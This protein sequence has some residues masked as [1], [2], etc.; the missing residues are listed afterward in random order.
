MGMALPALMSIQFA[1][2]SELFHAAK[3][4]SW[5]QALITADGLRHAP[6]FSAPVAKS[7]WMLAL[8]AGLTVMLPSQMS[9]IDDFSRRWTDAVWTAVPAVRRYFGPHQVQYIYYGILTGYVV[10]SV[11]FIL[12]LREP[13]LM[14][15][16]L[17]NIN[18]LCLGATAVQL[19]W[20]NLTLLPRALRPRWYHVCG[21]IGCA[22][23]YL[24]LAGLVFYEKQLPVLVAWWRRM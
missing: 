5:S 4:M 23:F 11:V 24:G 7:L 16:I 14:T 3:P 2:F 18:N 9:I 13:R 10:W 1:E 20:I 17:A 12:F 19:L 21:L 15:L 8:V 22:V 6:D